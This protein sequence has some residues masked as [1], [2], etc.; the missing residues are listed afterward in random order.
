MSWESMD[1]YKQLVELHPNLS[2]KVHRDAF[3]Q[4]LDRM[5]TKPNTLNDF[6][7]AYM[8]F[9]T[10]ETLAFPKLSELTPDLTVAE[11]NRQSKRSKRRRQ[12]RRRKVK[13]S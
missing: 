9:T 6:A 7:K 8:E 4:F 5:W 10:K 13:T 12:R 11:E 2:E 3:H 1:T